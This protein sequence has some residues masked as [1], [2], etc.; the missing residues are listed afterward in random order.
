[1][2]MKGICSLILFL[3]SFTL[4]GVKD[5]IYI[6]D[7]SN[8]ISEREAILILPGFG[9]KV[10]GSKAQAD[11]FFNKGVDVFIPKYIAR[12][13]IKNCVTNIDEFITKYNLMGYKKVHVFCY[14][15]G[16][17]TFNQWILEHPKNNISSIVYDRS[18]LQERAPYALVKD[19]PLIIRIISGKIMKEFSKTPYT[20]IQ[21]NNISIGIVIESKATKLIRKHK[22]SALSLGPVLWD[23]EALKQDYSDFCYTWLDHDGM[24]T[25]FDVIGNDILY[26]FKNGKFDSK[27]NRNPFN[28]D[29]FIPYIEK[30]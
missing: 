28:E 19:V 16:G 9:S 7:A 27:A 25:R 23:E 21:K 18:P 26:F 29:P 22:K 13:S 12:K 30:K 2:V 10:H 4:F 15:A 17:W 8:P 5:R 3:F 6:A 1:M 14:I 20:P 11:F 24:Y